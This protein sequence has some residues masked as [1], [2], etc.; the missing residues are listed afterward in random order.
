MLRSLRKKKNMS[1]KS[2]IYYRYT[3][4]A[5]GTFSNEVTPDIDYLADETVVQ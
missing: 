2:N 3:N 4:R 1:N 5:P